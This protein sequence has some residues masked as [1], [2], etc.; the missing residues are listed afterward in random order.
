MSAGAMKLSDIAS[1]DWSLML[2]STAQNLGLTS[3]IGNVVEGLDDVAQCIAII[4]TTPPGSDPL[5]PDFACDLFQFVD[6]PLS[7][8]L[9]AIVAQVTDALELWEPRIRTLSVTA[10]PGP[11][12]GQL[13]VT[14]E[15]QL[16]LPGASGPAQTTAVA[17]GAPPLNSL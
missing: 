1:A 13:E 7:Q 2:D 3:G 10:Q 4:L 16:N 5:R 15:W 6:R 11:S 14:V 8:A 17:I 9:A 12:L